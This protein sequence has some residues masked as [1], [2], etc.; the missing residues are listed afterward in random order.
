MTGW[1]TL[2]D[3]AACVCRDVDDSI[4]R[5]FTENDANQS[6]KGQESLS[7]PLLVRDVCVPLC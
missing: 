2:C 7:A 1:D 5:A 3:L 4:G 6:P